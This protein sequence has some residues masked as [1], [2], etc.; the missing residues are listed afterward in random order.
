MVGICFP[1]ELFVTAKAGS[2][3]FWNSR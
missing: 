1:I 2:E 3:N